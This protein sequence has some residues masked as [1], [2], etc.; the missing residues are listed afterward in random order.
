MRANAAEMAANP[1]ALVTNNHSDFCEESGKLHADLLED[2]HQISPSLDVEHFA[3]L[4]DL[5]TDLRERFKAADQAHRYAGL[6]SVD[7]REA[8]AS[9]ADEARELD[10]AITRAVEGCA[11]ELV[12]RRVVNWQELASRDSALQ[13]ASL[14]PD[15]LSEATI[16]DVGLVP[17]SLDSQPHDWFDGDT[18][19]LSATV[20]AEVSLEGFMTK[21]DYYVLDDDS[22]SVNDA[23]WNDHYM[24]VGLDRAI[25]LSFNLLVI[26]CAVE[27]IEFEG[28][29]V[30]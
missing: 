13:V 20:E 9:F 15:G 28:A 21:A 11:A 23:D 24:E 25:Q 30:V 26:G 16:T 5:L 19:A 27:S 18:V 10:A 17:N 2:V 6:F 4:R 14:L 7:E 22:I 29:E 1:P 3:S 12:G 8:F